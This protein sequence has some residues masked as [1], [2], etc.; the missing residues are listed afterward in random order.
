MNIQQLEYIIALDKERHFRK[1]AESCNVAQPTLSMMVQKLEDEIGIL[2]FDRKKKPIVPTPD[3]EIVLEYAR[4]VVAQ[5]KAIQYLKVKT[6]RK[7]RG[8][9][10]LGVLPTIAPYLVPLFVNSFM[11]E[12][13]GIKLTIREHTAHEIIDLLKHSRIDAGI[14]STPLNEHSIAEEVLY[15]EPF[16]LYSS[17]VTD[18]TIHSISELEMNELWMLEDKHCYH[19]QV[20]EIV[21][22]DQ[23]SKDHIVY[24]AGNLETLK[25]LVDYQQGSTILPELATMF[26][27]QNDQ[28][29]VLP[30]S[31]P[32]PYREVSLC[33]LSKKSKRSLL[34]ALKEQ[35]T[36]NVPR[37]LR[38]MDGGVLIPPY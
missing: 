18:G 23:S 20:N 9:I 34:K 5:T 3:G 7:L 24:K 36:L 8:K 25:K 15:R 1:A 17:L 29:K 16:K 19:M 28:R 12:Y 22:K 38:E 10:T 27:N 31:E 21:A 13:P 14:L 30:F 37:S 2:I 33:S 32:T 26:L 11:R 6:K 35:I 4:S